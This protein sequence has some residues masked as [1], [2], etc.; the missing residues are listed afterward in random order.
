M[1]AFHLSLPWW[2]QGPSPWLPPAFAGTVS[3]QHVLLH[4]NTEC[5]ANL[6]QW[7][8]SWD[9]K[10]CS[11]LLAVSL[12]QKV[13]RK[14]S[15]PAGLEGRPREPWKCTDAFICKSSY[16]WLV[17]LVLCFNLDW[18]YCQI[19]KEMSLPLLMKRHNALRS[20]VFRIVSIWHTFPLAWRTSFLFV[21]CSLGALVIQL[22][23][24]WIG[25]YF[26]LFL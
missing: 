9:L 11:A 16:V 13:E 22:F 7:C 19:I 24:L 10:W 17:T 15:G 4:V 18:W 25:L 12:N 14:V 20:F 5:L 23:N 8:W 26:A 2:W 3:A 6:D 21:S 1:Q